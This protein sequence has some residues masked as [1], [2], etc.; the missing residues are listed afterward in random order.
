FTCTFY[1]V[2]F[3]HSKKVLLKG[4]APWG[5]TLRGG[6]EHKEPLVITKVE[7]GSAAAGGRLQVGDELVGVNS[8]ILCGSRQEAI[9]LVKSSHRTLSLLIKPES[10]QGLKSH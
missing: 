5:F 9:T 8:V 10:C 7:S 3:H 2:T 6:T 1:F 4:K